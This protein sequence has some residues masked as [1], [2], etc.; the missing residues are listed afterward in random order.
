MQGK[1]DD[2]C[3]VDE[4]AWLSSNAAL[5]HTVLGFCPIFLTV[6][7]QKKVSVNTSEDVFVHSHLIA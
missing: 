5:L 1:T 2:V 4:A 6:N 7:F 3:K